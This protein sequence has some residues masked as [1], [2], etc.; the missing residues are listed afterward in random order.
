[1]ENNEADDAVG[2]V[3][4][5]K[6]HTTEE[7]PRPQTRESTRIVTKES[8]AADGLVSPAG[9]EKGVARG[10][11]RASGYGAPKKT[12]DSNYMDGLEPTK[13]QIHRASF[14]QPFSAD[15]LVRAMTQSTLKST[16]VQA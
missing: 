2:N 14:G 4:M 1:M 6:Q 13:T 3:G 10:N 16:A 12:K 15:D 5:S 9:V 11:D 7:D 8:L